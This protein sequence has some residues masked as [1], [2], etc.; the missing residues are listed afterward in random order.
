MPERRDAAVQESTSRIYIISDR[1]RKLGSCP[2]LCTN[3]G[4]SLEDHICG[5]SVFQIT[6]LVHEQF[7]F[8]SGRKSKDVCDNEIWDNAVE[9]HTNYGDHACSHDC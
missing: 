1:P 2:G 5:P 3:D 9:L 7:K 4:P 8:V 6:K